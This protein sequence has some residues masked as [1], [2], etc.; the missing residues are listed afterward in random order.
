MKRALNY[1]SVALKKK[2]YVSVCKL[3]YVLK[4]AETYLHTFGPMLSASWSRAVVCRASLECPTARMHIA[5]EQSRAAYDIIWAVDSNS[6]TGFVV[7]SASQPTTASCRPPLHRA[8]SGDWM[9]VSP[10]PSSAGPVET[11][12]I[13]PRR[14]G[15]WTVRVHAHSPS[16][17]APAAGPPYTRREGEGAVH[18]LSSVSSLPHDGV[19]WH[20]TRCRHGRTMG[21]PAVVATCRGCCQWRR[22]RRR[23]EVAP[24]LSFASAD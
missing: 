11:V 20:G 23:G 15:E 14:D 8:Q 7:Q 3:R 2:L 4:T 1:L 12:V 18:T 9:S 6:E 19:V 22:L 16:L 13:R 24:C 10:I 21:L 5:R 17:R